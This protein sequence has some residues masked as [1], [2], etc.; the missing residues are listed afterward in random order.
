MGF[1]VWTYFLQRFTSVPGFCGY[2][3]S[4]KWHQT[5][6]AAPFI[7]WPWHL[8]RNIPKDDWAPVVPI[9]RFNT[10]QPVWSDDKDGERDSPK[11]V[12]I[13]MA[14]VQQKTLIDS[15][16][17]PSRKLFPMLGLTFGFFAEDPESW[18][19]RD[20]SK[21]LRQRLRRFLLQMTTQ[22]NG[23]LPSFKTL[24]SLDAL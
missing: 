9:G 23:V 22:K 14:A 11:W 19:S 13:D 21:L 10:A 12:H 2:Y 3:C 18:N 17:K 7:S 24:H 1:F 15:F 4:Q 6:A 8:C 5:P 20:D 16:T